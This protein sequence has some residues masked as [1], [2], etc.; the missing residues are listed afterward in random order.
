MRSDRDEPRREDERPGVGGGGA[1]SP[2]V[3][4]TPESEPLDADADARTIEG[5]QPN[6][7]AV[8]ATPPVDPDVGVAE[9]EMPAADALLAPMMEKTGR[10]ETRMEEAIPERG[11]PAR[12]ERETSVR[13]PAG[14]AAP[15]PPV[16]PPPPIPP[17]VD[18]EELN[19]EGVRLAADPRAVEARL[20]SA[21][22]G[23][24]ALLD[25]PDGPGFLFDAD[26]ATPDDRVI[27]VAELDPAPPLWFVGD[28]HGDLL[29]LES[30]LA[31]ARRASEHSRLVLLGD[32]FDDGAYGLAV[33]IR[34]FELLAESPESICVVTGNHDEALGW[35]GERFTAT[36]SPSDFSEFLNAHLSDEWIVRAGRLA[37]RLFANAPRAL[38]FPDGL[39]V[40]H[41]GFPLVDLHEELRAAGDW[42]APRCLIDFVWTRAHP[43]ARKK[44]PNRASRGSQFGHE[45]FDA[46]CAL[47]TELGRPVT[48]MVRGHDHEEE[49]WA[50][51]PAYKRHPVLTTVALSR[52]LPR[53]IFGPHVRV[54]TMARWVPGALPQLHRL[55][56]PE[57]LVRELYPE[58]I[59]EEVEEGMPGDDPEAIG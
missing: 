57:P 16:E 55:H 36:V 2:P 5:E 50:I 41:G 52:R 31:L 39:L 10:G 13:T 35:N 7:D 24:E 44:I 8:P 51:Y 25:R 30:A 19:W 34:V 53:E 22:E 21:V 12:R 45:D 43:K 1:G 4:L 46:F 42:N 18:V 54:P 58:A 56:V 40:A 27:R 6:A 20:P 37:I 48:H 29:A 38:F 23:L 3:P 14:T 49:R 9:G 59:E 15:A 28:L 32:L 17:V 11:E 26:R 47:A 33:L